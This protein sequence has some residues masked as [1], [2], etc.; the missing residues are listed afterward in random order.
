MS[1]AHLWAVAYNDTERADRVRDEIVRLGWEEHYLN[2]L[3]TA[4]VVRHPD[5]S[6]TFDRKST[7]TVES[8]LGSG[9]V[10]FLA[11]LV[12]GAH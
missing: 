8:L 6:F 4:V 2:L 7:N 3:D 10:G 12:L 11:G 9:A 5:G 1:T